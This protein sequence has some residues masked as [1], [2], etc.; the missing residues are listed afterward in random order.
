MI[1]AHF[2]VYMPSRESLLLPI[3]LPSFGRLRKQHKCFLPFILR[4]DMTFRSWL[5]SCFQHA[6]YTSLNRPPYQ[7]HRSEWVALSD[8][9]LI[10]APSFCL[11][12]SRLPYLTQSM[13]TSQ[14]TVG[15]AFI[16]GPS[17]FSRVDIT[18]C[19]L[20]KHPRWLSNPC[21]SFLLTAHHQF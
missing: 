8:H 20:R 15:L 10:V 21:R 16:G 18:R 13:S 11:G 9:F 7:H 2:V 6:C 1:A 5:A 19:C 14:V 3:E 12:R 4:H 17:L